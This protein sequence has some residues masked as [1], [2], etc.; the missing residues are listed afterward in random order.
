[1]NRKFLILLFATVGFS[2]AMA[3]EAKPQLELTL[4]AAKTYA[5]ENNK[6]LQ[7]ASLDVKQAHAKR[8]QSIAAMLPQVDASVQ[9][10]S[11]FQHK[12]QFGMM[13]V[14]MTDNLTHTLTTSIG[15]NGQ[16][17]VGA[18][19]N[20]L[21]I[22]MQNIT[23]EKKESE[24]CANVTTS[25]L[26][27]LVMED[28]VSLLN[29]SLENVQRLAEMT[30]HTVDAGVAEQTQADQIKVKVN[31]LK[32]SINSNKR[33][34][35][36]A[37]NSL[38]VLLGVGPD[39]ELVLTQSLDELLSAEK[40][41]DLLHEDF[42]LAN[43]FDYQL[44]VKN[45]ELAKKNVVMA[46]MAYT[47]TVS[48]FYQ[49]TK[50][51]YFS[52]E[53]TLD[54]SAPHTAGFSVSIPIWSS[55]KRAA[56]ITEKKLAYQA[57]ENTLKETTDNLGI[58]NQQLRF[59]LA[60]A[61]ETYVNERENIAVTQTIFANT[62]KKFEQ[63]VASSLELTNASNDLISAQSTYVQAV[64]SLVKAQVDLTKFLNK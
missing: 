14:P 8:W 36:L 2:W 18:L 5:L 41:L 60:N 7:N 25:Y 40:A 17:I 23:K 21:A 57:A 43:N 64:L 50:K 33:N 20:N 52:D 30:Q 44:L 27:V 29:S 11:M 1:M 58:Q 46:G 48:A 22:E 31:T 34:T 62:S 13:E 28:I 42:V 12:M 3:Q 15:L 19:L 38:K 6:S 56:G 55:G 35:E 53:K 54:M 16:A 63:G 4:E 26:T 49:Y 24:I 37:R 59:N 51:K 47:P 10:S 45:T 9:F 61:Y 39:A 32:N